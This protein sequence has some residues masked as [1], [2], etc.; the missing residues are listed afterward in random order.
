MATAANPNGFCCPFAISGNGSSTTFCWSLPPRRSRKTIR[1]ACAR[2]GSCVD[3]PK[4]TGHNTLLFEGIGTQHDSCS[5]PKCY[6]VKLEVHVRQPWPRS[7]SWYR[8]ARHYGQPKDG[9]AAIPRNKYVEIRQDKPQKKEAARLAGIQDVQVHRR[10][11]R[12]RGQ[13]EGRTAPGVRQSRMP[14][15][16][17]EEE[18]TTDTGR[19]RLQGRTGEAP[20]RGGAG[21]HDRLRVLKAIGEAVPV[22]LMKRD[23]LFAVTRLTAL[24]DERRVAVLIRQHG[25]GKP[26][27]GE[28]PAKLL[29][30]FLPKAEESQ[31]GRILVETVILLSMRPEADSAKVL[32]DAAQTYKVDIEAITA[33][34]KQEFAAKE[35]AMSAKKPVSKPAAKPT[36]KTAA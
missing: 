11:H 13:R 26:K 14:G 9:S 33:N 28:A 36:K 7:R 23:L 1:N 29:A 19:R 27:D 17:S 2:G 25:I 24:L 5:D 10:G 30:A 15:P 8:S 21:P 6:A 35:K 16:S 34:V 12:H 18:A 4:R 31:L 32:R 3:C 20:P 22:R